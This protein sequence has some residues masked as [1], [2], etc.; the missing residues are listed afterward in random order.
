MLAACDS[1]HGEP[2]NSAPIVDVASFTVD[3]DSVLSGQLVATDADDDALSFALTMPPGHGT[4]TL[5]S[6]GV[7]EYRPHA[8]VSGSDS[9]HFALTDGRGAAIDGSAQITISPVN[10]PPT[11]RHDILQLP[12]SGLDSIAV[13]SNDTDRDGDPLVLSSADAPSVG[14]AELNAD[15]TVRIDG[16]AADFRGLITFSYSAADGSSLATA[17]AAVFVDT[18]PFAAIYPRSDADG[19]ARVIINDFVS[20]PRALTPAGT[21]AAR[22]RNFAPARSGTVL[23]Y[24]M[25][26]TAAASTSSWFCI[27]ESSAESL[28]ICPANPPGLQ[29]QLIGN[30][31]YAV[32]ADGRWLAA[33][34]AS[35]ESVASATEPV[36][37]GLYLLDTRSPQTWQQVLN[38]ATPVAL[39]PRFSPDS[40]FLYYLGAETFQRPSSTEPPSENGTALNRVSMDAP[41]AAPVRLTGDPTTDRTI[42]GYTVARDGSVAIIKRLNRGMLMVHTASPGQE[43]LLLG[44]GS[45]DCD[46]QRLSDRETRVVAARAGDWD[47]ADVSENP[48]RRTVSSLPPP[49]P[50]SGPLVPPA[51]FYIGTAY[52]NPNGQYLVYST[53]RSIA[54]SVSDWFISYHNSVRFVPSASD[55]CQ[56]LDSEHFGAAGDNGLFATFDVTG[57]YCMVTAMSGRLDLRVNGIAIRAPFTPANSRSTLHTTS[58]QPLASAFGDGFD[59]DRGAFLSAVDTSGSPAGSRSYRPTLTNF[60]TLED[61]LP[62]DDNA[63]SDAFLRAPV[64]YLVGAE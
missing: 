36:Q 34:F 43:T 5:S 9:F 15:N 16:L 63:V 23:A 2:P 59:M 53:A 42:C 64:L 29:P 49:P 19:F 20:P 45:T 35:P 37:Q 13:L 52:V 48:N 47:V 10:D 7:F 3:E 12:R 51:P 57:H 11:V 27:V 44:S 50:P 8:D 55:G 58:R 62:I 1:K 24:L 4:L 14:V 32:S 26:D 39:Q 22:L 6:S 33:A 31:F 28:P 30:R 54:P 60:S 46:V 61:S 21:P 38:A 40:R 25:T 56:G 41:L 18:A 17:N